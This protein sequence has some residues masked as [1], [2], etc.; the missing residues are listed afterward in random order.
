MTMVHCAGMREWGERCE[1]ERGK[2]EMG[3]FAENEE[4]GVKRLVLECSHM[5]LNVPGK[6]GRN[7]DLTVR[8]RVLK[9]VNIR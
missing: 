4:C 9:L 3:V 1:D 8:N 5:A 7:L 2:A 6:V